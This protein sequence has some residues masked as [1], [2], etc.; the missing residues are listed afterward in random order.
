VVLFLSELGEGLHLG[1]HNGADNSAVF[2]D[3]VQRHVDGFSFLLVFFGVFGKGFFL[4]AHPVLVESSHSVFV[5]FLGPD[6]GK[7]SKSSGSVDVSDQSDNGDGGGLENGDGLNDFFFVEFGSGS[8]DVSHNVGH[9][10]L[11]TSECGEVASLFGVVFREGSYATM[12]VSGSAFGGET[13]IAVTGSF[14]FTVRHY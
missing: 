9:T 3:S 12:V 5:Q 2:S 8:F 7:G 1:G 4:R 11:E 13:E 14:E 6:G 10:G